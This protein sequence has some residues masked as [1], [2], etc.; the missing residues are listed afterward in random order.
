MIQQLAPS[1]LRTTPTIPGAT[2]MTTPHG[3]VA[4][5]ESYAFFVH[6]GLPYR[7]R[8]PRGLTPKQ[9]LLQLRTAVRHAVEAPERIERVKRGPQ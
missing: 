2:V 7:I 8:L 9:L 3:L 4:V 5:G 6:A 1:F